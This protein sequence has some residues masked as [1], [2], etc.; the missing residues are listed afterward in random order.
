MYRD[1]EHLVLVVSHM[2]ATTDIYFALC[3]NRATENIPSCGNI[4]R[5]LGIFFARPMIEFEPRRVYCQG[6][7][8]LWKFLL[9]ADASSSKG[10][11]FA[12][13]RLIIDEPE[14]LARLA[15]DMLLRF[16]NICIRH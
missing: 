13:S 9:N 6:T 4:V 8:V 16:Q 15:L 2:Q 14:I 12:L 1:R 5:F 3:L 10:R 7:G 11:S